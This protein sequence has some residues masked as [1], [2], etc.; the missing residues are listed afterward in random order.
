MTRR[1]LIL[2]CDPGHDDAA[3]IALAVT[4]GAFEIEA[5]TAVCG[6]APLERTSANALSIADALGISIPT[7]KRDW[8][9]ARVWLHR[10][11]HATRG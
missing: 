2:D 1:R 3:A 4:S 5:I 6:N 11:I 8:A 9:Y 7:A 10:E